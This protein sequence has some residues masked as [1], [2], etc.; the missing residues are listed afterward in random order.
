MAA[1]KDVSA[2]C[3]SITGAVTRKIGSPG[4][5]TVP[6]GMA[7]TSPEKR[8]LARYSKKLSPMDSKTGSVRR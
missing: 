1:S 2:I 3:A 8:N 7:Q 4:K 5:N 6:S